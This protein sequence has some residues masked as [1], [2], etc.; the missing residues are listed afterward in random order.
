MNRFGLLRSRCNPQITKQARGQGMI[1]FALLIP[2]LVL[3]VFG[4]IDLALAYH[5]QV[6]LTNASRE[7]ARLAMRI[8]TLFDTDANKL[9]AIRQRVVDEAG[10]SGIDII[11]GDVTAI[12]LA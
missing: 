4:A 1:E 12:C 11:P 2:L 5:A 3:I 8:N 7:G 9:Q 6:T 10:A